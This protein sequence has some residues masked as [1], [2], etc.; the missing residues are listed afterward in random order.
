MIRPYVASDWPEVCRVYDAAKPLELWSGGV[1]ASFIP[2]RDDQPR[3][4]EFATSTVRVWDEGRSLLGFVGYLED[5]IGWLFV[6]PDAFRKGIGRA[7]LSAALREIDGD[8]YLWTMRENQPAIRLYASV[9]FQIAEHR[10]TQNRGMP[11]NAVKMKRT[12]AASP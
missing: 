11:C 4:D 3:I 12:Q 7:L 8:P 6:H 9:G 5:F 10:Q 1:A 2:L